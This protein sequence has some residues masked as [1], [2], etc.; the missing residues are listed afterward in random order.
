VAANELAVGIRETYYNT[1][2]PQ[3]R[4]HTYPD[5]VHLDFLMGG[6]DEDVLRLEPR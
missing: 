2:S 6:G 1:L 5:T 3:F 4:I